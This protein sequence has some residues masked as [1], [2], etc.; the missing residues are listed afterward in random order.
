[1]GEIKTEEPTGN[2]KRTKESLERR[3]NTNFLKV[4]QEEM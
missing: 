1:V 2:E 4:F 3:K